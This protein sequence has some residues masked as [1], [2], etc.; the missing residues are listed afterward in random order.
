MKTFAN[1][2]THPHLPE[3]EREKDLLIK[4]EVLA[5]YPRTLKDIALVNC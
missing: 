4:F 5:A 1:A 2:N 3:R